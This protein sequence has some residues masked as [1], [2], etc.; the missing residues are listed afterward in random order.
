[1]TVM[2]PFPRKNES[3][4]ILFGRLGLNQNLAF[5]NSNTDTYS[6]SLQ[7]APQMWQLAHEL[8]LKCSV[9]LAVSKHL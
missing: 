2:G 4:K 3:H 7:L 9:T 5:F 1:M 6:I 8:G